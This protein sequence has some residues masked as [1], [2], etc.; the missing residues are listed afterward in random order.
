M[1]DK[2]TEDLRAAIAALEG[3]R[4]TLGDTVLERA[5]ASPPSPLL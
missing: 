4:T 1:H 2:D 3:Q 5:T